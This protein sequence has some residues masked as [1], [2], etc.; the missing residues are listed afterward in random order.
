[1]PTFHLPEPGRPYVLVEPA[2]ETSLLEVDPAAIVDLYKTHGAL[3]LR[4]FDTQ[5]PDFRRF[6][7]I[8]CPTSVMNESPGRQP[9]EPQYNIHTVDGG[10]GAF[11]LHPEL[12]REPWKPDAAFF[13][14]FS[15]PSQ[16]GS[17]TM[18]DGVELV[19]HLP[20]VVRRGLEGRRL[21]YVKPTWPGLLHYWLGTPTPSDALLARPPASCPY[22]FLRIEDDVLRIFTRPALNKPMFI[23]A[24][25]FGNFLLFARFNNGRPDHPVF[26][27]GNPVPEAWLQAI[28]AVGDQ[29]SVPVIWQKGDVVMLDNTRF[30]HGRTPILDARERLIATFFGYVGF[31]VPDPEE[32]PNPPWRRADFYPPLPPNLQR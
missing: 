1:M 3:L 19:R 25:A 13:A 21:L 24:P 31:A 22:S 14:C 8:F 30:M 27:D 4:G 20:D 6:A 12:S 10:T 18:C 17:T 15:A 5:V 32:P 2:G 28:K 9:I 7:R 11:N 23:D 16:G 29:L 26:E